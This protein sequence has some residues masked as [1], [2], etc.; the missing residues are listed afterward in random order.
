MRPLGFKFSTKKTQTDPKSTNLTDS[1]HVYLESGGIL[2]SVAT[3]KLNL[4]VGK[5][6]SDEILHIMTHSISHHMAWMDEANMTEVL[7]YIAACKYVHPPGGWDTCHENKRM[8]CFCLDGMWGTIF[9]C[10]RWVVWENGS[11]ILFPSNPER[12]EFVH[13]VWFPFIVAIIV[14]I[15]N[16]RGTDPTRAWTALNGYD[17]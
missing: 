9:V 14:F 1:R 12:C 6:D 17:N 4:P 15:K 11:S 13:L 2:C 3:L 16:F 7:G 8:P 5:K 10:F